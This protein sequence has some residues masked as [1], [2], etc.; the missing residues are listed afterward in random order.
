MWIRHFSKE[1]RTMFSASPLWFWRQHQGH[2]QTS[3]GAT[4]EEPLSESTPGL[5]CRPPSNPPRSSPSGLP[6]NSLPSGP[7]R[8]SWGS[9]PPDGSARAPA[10]HGVDGGG[11]V[12]GPRGG[13]ERPWSTSAP[14]LSTAGPRQAGGPGA[15]VA[16]TRERST[17]RQVQLSSLRRAFTAVQSTVCA[18]RDNGDEGGT[19][20]AAERHSVTTSCE[21]MKP[22]MPSEAKIRYCC[23]G[24]RATVR[25][26]GSPEMMCCSGGPCGLPQ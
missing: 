5:S 24:C 21:D 18:R 6:R 10:R 11:R 3:S 26:S 15:K 7:L 19:Q 1:P 25:S 2:Q 8:N 9:K 14:R 13:P 12:P 20:P 22:K 4:S 16:S 17:M 23:P